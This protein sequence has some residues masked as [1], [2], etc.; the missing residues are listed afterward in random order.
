M[1]SEDKVRNGQQAQFIIT[2]PL[3][4]EAFEAIDKALNDALTNAPEKDLE[5]L[6][7]LVLTKKCLKRF[8]HA[9]ERHIET[10][11]IAAKDLEAK[12]PLL[13]RFM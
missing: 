5:G 2:H 8:R 10:G 12:K 11:K 4:V 1:N 9:F 13:H 6:K 7:N 3:V